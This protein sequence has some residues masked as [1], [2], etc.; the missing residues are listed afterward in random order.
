MCNVVQPYAVHQADLLYLQHDKVGRKTYKDAITVV[1]IASRCKGAEAK[2]DKSSTKAAA[3]LT[4]I[5]KRG[6]LT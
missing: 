2:T 3:A 4:R 1:D 6:S 5:Y